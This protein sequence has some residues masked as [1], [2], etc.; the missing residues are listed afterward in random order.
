MFYSVS[1]VYGDDEPL[2]VFPEGLYHKEAKGTVYIVTTSFITS[3]LHF[4]RP[5]STSHLMDK[6]ASDS[7][8]DKASFKVKLYWVVEI[9]HQ[10]TPLVAQCLLTFLQIKHPR[11]QWERDRVRRPAHPVKSPLG[12]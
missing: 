9:P 6:K 11:V 1:T 3:C 8:K 10:Q 5:V 4:G 7:L 12:V 2:S